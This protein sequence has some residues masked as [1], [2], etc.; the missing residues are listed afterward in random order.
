MKAIKM[1]KIFWSGF[2]RAFFSFWLILGLSFFSLTPVFAEEGS[3]T[4]E[5]VI[6]TGDATSENTVENEVNS[7][8][9]TVGQDAAPTEPEA[10]ASPDEVTVEA[11]NTNTA[12]ADTLAA[13]G[14]AWVRVAVL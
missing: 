8:V 12:E 7:N 11:Q 13:V 9:T 1:K 6:V 10:T 4:P 5:T 14:L 2:F 3:S